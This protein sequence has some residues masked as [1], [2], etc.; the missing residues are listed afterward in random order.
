MAARFGNLLYWLGTIV[1]VLAIGSAIIGN[2]VVFYEVRQ[3]RIEVEQICGETVG[4]AECFDKLAEEENK[5][6]AESGGIDIRGLFVSVD[7]FGVNATNTRQKNSLI[8]GGVMIL[9]GLIAFGI[10]WAARYVLRG[11]S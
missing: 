2:G 1:A 7:P 3:L 11:P 4:E 10:G 9:I 8:F 6:T 5:R